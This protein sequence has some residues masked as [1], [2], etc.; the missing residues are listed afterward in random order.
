VLR[1]VII[2]PQL[3]QAIVGFVPRPCLHQFCS[4]SD[5]AIRSQARQ[6]FVN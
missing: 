5:V 4:I 1:I 3:N 2:I 6:T